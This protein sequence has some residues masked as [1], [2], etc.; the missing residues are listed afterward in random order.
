M[1][2]KKE[3][4]K[5]IQNVEQTLSHTEQFLEQN[6]KPLLYSL[7]AVVIVVGIFWLLRLSVTRQNKEAQGQ[8]FTAEQYFGQDSLRLALY[9]DGNNLG[10]IDIAKEYKRTRSGR[11]ANFYAGVCLVHMGQFEEAIGYLNRYTLHDEI[12]APEAK[13]LIGDANV[14]MG[15]NDNGIKYYLEA[16]ALADNS[17][18]SPIYL[19]KAGML[20]ELNGKYADALKLY[21]EIQDKYPESNEG[22]SIE[23]YIARVKMHLD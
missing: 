20:Y 17:F 8:M 1:S 15:N 4:E 19:M 23:K 14:E 9:G 22:R 6:Y 7:L 12:L 21:E 18:H 16:A 13:G 2:K 3:S 5:G 11:L 10:F